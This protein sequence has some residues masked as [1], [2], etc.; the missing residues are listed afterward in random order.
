MTIGGYVKVDWGWSDKGIGSDTFVA[1][2]KSNSVVGFRERRDAEYGVMYAGVGETRL[3]F[4]VKGPDAWGAKTSAF[5]EFDFRGAGYGNLGSQNGASTYDNALIRHAFMKFDWQNDSLLVGKFWANYNLVP[6]PIILTA[7]NELGEAKNNRVTQIKWTHMFGKNLSTNL[8][9]LAPTQDGMGRNGMDYFGVDS[10]YS[11]SMAPFLS[12]GIDFASDACGKIGT[13]KLAFGA[14]GLIGY[15]KETWDSP[16]VAR[17]LDDKNV[18]SWGLSTYFTVPII[19]ERNNNKAGAWGIAGG[20]KVDSNIQAI[21]G[22]V[23]SVNSGAYAR[24]LGVREVA[25]TWLSYW[26]TTNF[27]FTDKVS[28]NALYA[29]TRLATVSNVWRR[30]AFGLA[31]LQNDTYSLILAYQVNPAITLAAE[32]T[33]IYTKYG[34]DSGAI[35]GNPNVPGSDRGKAN[36]FRMGAWYYF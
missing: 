6:I 7:F 4:L 15:T 20:A 10:Q 28:I 5:V 13:T 3:N 1:P 24:G 11:R 16:T 31:P 14:S 27:Y 21:N 29:S 18:K 9:F 33:Q 35:A 32:A 25:P 23:I 26:A 22:P 12:G 36:V 2:R 34:N 17:N 30:T 8:A 19:P